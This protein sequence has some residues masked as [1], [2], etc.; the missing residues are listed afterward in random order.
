MEPPYLQLESGNLYISSEPPVYTVSQYGAVIPF[1]DFPMDDV[2]VPS[3]TVSNPLIVSVHEWK[4]DRP[5]LTIEDDTGDDY[6][7]F[8][9]LSMYESLRS[10]FHAKNLR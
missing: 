8:Q 10:H 5:M 7:D 2:F 6:W 3:F 1:E 9:L 4:W